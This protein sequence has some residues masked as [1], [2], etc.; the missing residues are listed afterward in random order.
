MTAVAVFDFRPSADE[1]LQLRL[2]NGWRPTASSLKDGDRILGHAA[3][4]IEND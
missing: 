2:E 4:T 1:L 3:C